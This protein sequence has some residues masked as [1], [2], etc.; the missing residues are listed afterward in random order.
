M[1]DIARTTL[2]D[3]DFA[4]TPSNATPAP[5]TTG[6]TDPRLMSTNVDPINPSRDLN[7]VHPNP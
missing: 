2:R 6:P 1:P 3:T 7:L 4:G 5:V